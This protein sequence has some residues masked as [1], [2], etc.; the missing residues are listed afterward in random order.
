[1]AY[2]H[3]DVIIAQHNKLLADRAEAA[4]R[5]EQARLNEDSDG[6]MWAADHIVEC[7][8]KLAALN[9]IAS[10]YIAGQQQA[11]QGSK[12]GLNS[13]QAAVAHTIGQG[14]ARLTNDDR[15]RIY[16]EQRNKLQR[17]RASGEYR[18]TTE[19]TG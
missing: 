1:M 6:T 7:D 13:E 10:D 9:R 16:S 2:D 8:A 5:Y 17:M 3:R 4:G 15:E 12:Y 19:Q 18:H 11:Q 14:D